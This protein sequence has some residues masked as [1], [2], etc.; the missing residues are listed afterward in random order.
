MGKY[1]FGGLEK[2]PAN[3]LRLISELEGA[4]QL[5]KYMGF[6]EDMEILDGMKKPYYKLYFKLNKKQSQKLK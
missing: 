6:K 2:H 1:D 4:Y 3:I 5:C